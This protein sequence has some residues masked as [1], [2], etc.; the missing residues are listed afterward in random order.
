M[1]TR[2]N[3]KLQHKLFALGLLGS[4]TIGLLNASCASALTLPPISGI[5][6]WSNSVF[7]IPTSHIDYDTTDD[8]SPD[9]E[10]GAIVLEILDEDGKAVPG[11]VFEIDGVRA[12]RTMKSYVYDKDFGMYSRFTTDDSGRVVIRDVPYGT[13]TIH[14]ISS[15]DG[16]SVDNASKK[17]EVREQSATNVSYEYIELSSGDTSLTDRIILSPSGGTYWDIF[18]YEFQTAGLQQTGYGVPLI[19]DESTN[20]YTSESL[21]NNTIIRKEDDAFI[22]QEG[23]ESYELTRITDNLY[24]TSVRATDVQGGWG[25]A[26]T[27]QENP[28]GTIT[29]TVQ[30]E[31]GVLSKDESGCYPFVDA[32]TNSYENICK[33]G[34]T[35]VLNLKDD[36]LT[37]IIPMRY[38]KEYGKYI[39]NDIVMSIEV[40]ESDNGDARLLFGYATQFEPD[41]N[42]WTVFS[43]GVDI[44]VSDELVAESL[45]ATLISFKAT[46]PI[47]MDS[48]QSDEAQP[49]NPQTSDAILKTLAIAVV[50]VLS[51]AIAKNRLLK[52]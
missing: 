48:G 1:K 40:V 22:Y 52:R 38:D 3:S 8:E 45:P 43:M 15:P 20:G 31:D 41:L 13:Y 47:P 25:E 6:G 24:S 36:N 33:Q 30:G 27:V 50:C 7:Y 10:L 21:G 34:D 19:W 16:S 46:K 37:A 51:A 4:A 26:F 5:D 39:F 32:P 9:T 49:A 28:D 42:A 12:M 23:D 35:Y 17:V 29:A 14:Y 11:A 18:G 44:V 2:T